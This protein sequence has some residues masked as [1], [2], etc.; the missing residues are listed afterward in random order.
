VEE[1]VTASRVELQK[2]IEM[3]EDILEEPS[4]K[5]DSNF[6][7]GGGDSLLATRVISRLVRDYGVDLTFAEFTQAP[8]PRMLQELLDELCDSA[9]S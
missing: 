3:F 2:L 4:L 5:A 7:T 1:P 9:L 8:T 6:F